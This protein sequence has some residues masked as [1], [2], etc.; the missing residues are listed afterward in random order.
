MKPV[1]ILPEA[2]RDLDDIFDYIALDN[3]DAA[4]RTL[5]RIYQAASRL[6]LFPESGRE[7]PEVGEGARS[8][9]VGRY[10]LFY[11]VGRDNL[12]VARV[13]HGSRDLAGLLDQPVLRG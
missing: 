13:I 6:Q 5:N 7:R 3:A 1:D 10:L 4:T 8:I 9:L 12:E 11:R 2:R